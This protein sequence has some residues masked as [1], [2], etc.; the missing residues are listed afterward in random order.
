MGVGR[1][2]I[3]LD[4]FC[5]NVCESGV[6]ECVCIW[7]QADLWKK[8]GARDEDREILSHLMVSGSSRNEWNWPMRED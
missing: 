4:I 2:G 6:C 1:L 5:L 7:Q 3:L 8:I